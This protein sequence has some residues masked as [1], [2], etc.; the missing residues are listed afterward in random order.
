MIFTEGMM[1]F[2]EAAIEV[3]MAYKS[4]IFN[5]ELKRSVIIVTT[6]IC[7]RKR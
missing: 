2:D 4:P 1:V 5:V 6:M 7:V 3:W